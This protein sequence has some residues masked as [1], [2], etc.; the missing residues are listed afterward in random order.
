MNIRTI[1][2]LC[3]AIIS[4]GLYFLFTDE[5]LNPK[6]I[7]IQHKYTKPINTNSSANAYIELMSWQYNE[8]DAYQLAISK[9]NAM[10]SSLDTTPLKEISPIEYP[11]IK[12]SGVT[13]KRLIEC[14]FSEV[15]CVKQLISQRKKFEETIN[16]NKALLQKLYSL[17]QYTNFEPLNPLITSTIFEPINQLNNLAALDILY[18]IEDGEL[19]QAEQLIAT[20]ISLNRKLLS[21]PDDA[22]FKVIPLLNISGFYVPL[23]N[24]MS[25]QGYK[26]WAQIPKVISPLTFNEW[27][28]NSRVQQ[29]AYKAS[30]TYRFKHVSSFKTDLPPLISNIRTKLFY[31][32]NITINTLS[33]FYLTEVIPDNTPKAELFKKKELFTD[34]RD[35]NYT[36]ALYRYC[37]ACEV[38]LH[39]NNIVG[40]TFIMDYYQRHIDLS[41]DI[42]NLDLTSQLLRLKIL[43]DKNSNNTVL[44]EKQWQEPYLQT[45]PFIKDDMICYHVEEDACINL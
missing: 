25:D 43:G 26:T 15:S 11:Q 22:M 42:I 37:N 45:Q 8:K 20:L 7:A 19:I 16:N 6:I 31:K 3:A 32:E 28:F 34:V 17:E 33:D 44:A 30:F 4:A 9:Y 40:Y 2:I 13:T 29:K 21:S 10:I 12:V 35:K 41:K 18:K 14:R 39:L 1:T 36:S 24:R 27:T 23:I 5:A 38:Y